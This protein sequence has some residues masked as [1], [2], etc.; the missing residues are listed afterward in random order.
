MSK[1]YYILD[2]YNILKQVHHITGVKLTQGRES[3][4]KFLIKGFSKQKMTVVFDGFPRLEEKLHK[5]SSIRIKFSRKKA[6]DDIIR[7]IVK[8]SEIKSQLVV[9]TD[10]RELR[11][12]LR[13]FRVKG[14]KVNEF[15]KRCYNKHHVFKKEVEK[16][17]IC[18][19]QGKKITDYFYKKL[20]EG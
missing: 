14:E 15:F 1:L 10:D 16:P 4:I 3:F 5:F 17:H 2:G 9:I 20:V 8:G 13:R 7:E 19:T 6:A 12:S 11:E 18:S